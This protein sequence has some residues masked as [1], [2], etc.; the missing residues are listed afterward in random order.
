MIAW[1][2]IGPIASC[3]EDG[4]IDNDDKDDDGIKRTFPPTNLANAGTSVPLGY[5]LVCVCVVSELC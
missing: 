1:L 2:F 5:L 3:Q 4:G